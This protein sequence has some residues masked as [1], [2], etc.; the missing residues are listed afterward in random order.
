[1]SAREKA[2]AEAKVS[3]A[4]ASPQGQADAN[5]QSTQPRRASQTERDAARKLAAA[6]E[7]PRGGQ[8]R[9]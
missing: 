9:A 1:M 2:E 4:Q 7:T 3:L 6:D 5:P 8:G